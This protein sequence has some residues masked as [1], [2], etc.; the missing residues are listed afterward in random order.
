MKQESDGELWT[1][2]PH[3]HKTVDA[4]DRFLSKLAGC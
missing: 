3:E 4:A 2:F 1:A